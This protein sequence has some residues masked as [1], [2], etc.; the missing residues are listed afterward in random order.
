MHLLQITFMNVSNLEIIYT[1]C[2]LAPNS[3]LQLKVGGAQQTIYHLQFK[4]DILIVTN[5]WRPTVFLY[6]S[7]KIFEYCPQIW[8]QI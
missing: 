5:N 7:S 1:W 3:F 4:E 2:V 6:K 8:N